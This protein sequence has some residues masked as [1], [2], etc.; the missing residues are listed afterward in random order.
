MKIKDIEFESTEH[1][2]QEIENMN[3]KGGSP[4]GR[5]AAWA[6]KLA[7]KKEDIGDLEELKKRISIIANQLSEYKPTMATIANTSKL[8]KDFTNA[9]SEDNFEE[10][11]AGVISLCDKIIDQSYKAVE[12]IAEFGS[13]RINDGDIIMMHSYSSTL[14]SIFIQAKNEGK[15]FEMICTES[16]PLRESRNAIKIFQQLEIPV[17][18]V[19]DASAFEIMPKCDYIIMGADS[20]DVDGSVAN[21]MGTAQIA[22]LAK[23][24]KKDVYI[25]SELFKLDL[26]TRDGYQIE[27]EKRDKY[28]VITKD[29]FETLDGLDVVNQFFDI[30]PSSDI[31]AVITESGF[32]H[33]SQIAAYWE[34]MVDNLEK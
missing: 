21:K 15:D 34:M 32:L 14:M 24:C 30:T 18:F 13:N 7:L 23:H 28:E 1:V 8:I 26:R 3:V 22:A 25:A 16:R 9:H 4:F 33:P 27:L 6:Y 5:A 19:T 12:K 10:L 11:K 20:I 17:T 29:D 2:M 31:K